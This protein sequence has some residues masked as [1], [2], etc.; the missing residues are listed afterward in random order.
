[1]IDPSTLTDRELATCVDAFVQRA[2]N[3]ARRFQITDMLT[4]I[5]TAQQ[6][7]KD[8]EYKIKHK[9]HIGSYDST[10]HSET[11]N[12]V[13]SMDNAVA[14]WLQDNLD[15]PTTVRPMITHQP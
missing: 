14:R 11:N 2:I 4:V 5:I 10:S 7:N 15:A 6:Y 3:N 13:N 12:L 1:M 9:A 8:S